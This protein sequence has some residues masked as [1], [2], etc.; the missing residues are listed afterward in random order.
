MSTRKTRRITAEDLYQFQLIFDGQLAPD[1][2]NAIFCQQRV[3]PKSHKTTSNLWVV[4]TEGGAPRQF[5]YGDQSDARPQWSPDGRQI[6]FLSNRRNEKQSQ[7]YIIPFY[8]GE[9]RPLTDFKGEFGRFQWSPDGKELGCAFRQKDQEAI[10]REEDE[11]LKELGVVAR[12]ITRLVFKE[13]EYGFLPQE[14]WQ[15]WRIEVETGQAQQL[16]EGDI[17]DAY[18]PA[19]SPDGR[20]L[21]LLSNRSPNPDLEWDKVD[22]W[23]MPAGGGDLRRLETPAGLKALPTY[24]PDGQWVA[25]Y[26]EGGR[27][28]LFEPANLWAVPAA[29]AG[30]AKNLTAPFDILATQATINDMG[31]M[32]ARPPIW[33]NDSQTIYF[34]ISQDGNTQLAAVAI[35]G[36]NLEKIIEAEGV[37]AEFSFDQARTQLIYLYGS[38][39]D[40]GQIWYDDLEARGRRPLT[41]VN[42][43]LLE[44]LDLGQIEAVWFKGADDNDLQ[45]WILKPPDFD[46]SR[47]YPSILEIHGGPMA[48]YG[49]FF[50]HE[51]YYLAAYDYVVYFCNPRGGWGYG[52]AHAQAIY[53]NWGGV[54]YA[55]LMAWTDWV[56]QKP[57][58]DPERMG[59]TGGSYGG[60]M[61]TW[62]IG[63]TDR[64]K[65]AVTQRSVSNMISMEGSSDIANLFQ[66][67]FGAGAQVWED[68]ETYW[69][70]S[71]LKYIGNVK[72]PTLVI[73]SEQDLRC[74]IEQGEQ[75][76]VALKKLGVETE[77]VRFPDE[78]HGLSRNGRTD[79]RIVRLKHILRWFDRYLK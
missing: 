57:Y 46:E 47:K 20:R 68:V 9:A 24:S 19:W 61:T 39:T 62:I 65:A 77:M 48:Q 75:I 52:R 28:N 18:D 69:R 6:A 74:N 15:I 33:S 31:R 1:G 12:H 25:Y 13:D 53:H 54:D 35:D 76:F 72:T 51:F 73:H 66:D 79:R 56:Q 45:G 26:A 40:P 41:Q 60:F 58:I 2:G 27:G 4:S 70:Q 17:Y 29:G 7:I 32:L 63:H 36:S 67:L 78:A 14:R 71:P 43:D 59:V 44:T 30:E 42:Q 5:T 16:T 50:M 10:E 3:D 55:D 11:R 8:G 23:V 38:L 37:V 64:F 34:Q 49:N 22:L 21:V